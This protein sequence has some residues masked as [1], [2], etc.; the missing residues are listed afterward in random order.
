MDVD[1]DDDDEL[2]SVVKL[3]VLG[4]TGIIGLTFNA[5][6]SMLSPAFS[7]P[8]ISGIAFSFSILAVRPEHDRVIAVVCCLLGPKPNVLAKNSLFLSEY[9]GDCWLLPLNLAAIIS[10]FLQL[11]YF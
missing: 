5:A 11:I 8:K 9:C 4:F 1:V 3:V 10:Q 6:S 7:R 2:F